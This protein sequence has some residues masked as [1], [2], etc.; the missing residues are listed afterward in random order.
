M[1][2]SLVHALFGT[3]QRSSYN[4][5]QLNSNI[6]KFAEALYQSGFDGENCN[7]ISAACNERKVG[8]WVG[9]VQSHS[10]SP[11]HWKLLSNFSD[12]P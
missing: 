4:R 11:L 12:K 3:R 8:A 7:D 10:H 1:A 2:V 5:M 9:H 6:S